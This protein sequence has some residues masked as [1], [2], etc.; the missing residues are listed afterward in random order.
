M[1]KKLFFTEDN[2]ETKGKSFFTPMGIRGADSSLLTDQCRYYK[3]ICLRI[4]GPMIRET[5]TGNR[6][7]NDSRTALFLLLVK[8]S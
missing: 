3:S 8:I 4:N 5:E 2:E 6:R 7:H 1:V